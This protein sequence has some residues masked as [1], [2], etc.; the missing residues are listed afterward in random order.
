MSIWIIRHGETAGNANRIVQMPETP[1]C[2]RGITQA[3]ALGA[4]L[5]S[6]PIAHILASDYARAAMTAE[7]VCATTGAAIESDPLLRERNFGDLRG[8]PYS[9]LAE[10]GIDIMKPGYAPPGGEDWETFHT[11]VDSAWARVREVA[12]ATDGDL[13]VVTHGLVCY[14]LVT[15][16]LLL[17]GESVAGMV[18]RSRPD[19]IEEPRGVFANA[20]VTVVDAAPPWR[21]QRLNCTE[22]LEHE[23]VSGPNSGAV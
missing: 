3:E 21:I 2:E 16:H 23:S 15:R 12:A 19:R 6:E 7:R 4:R 17:P 14:S 22:H 20:S 10:L 1:L 5:A 11:R 8:T 18:L 13:A 9:Q